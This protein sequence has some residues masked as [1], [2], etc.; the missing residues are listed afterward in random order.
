MTRRTGRRPGRSTTREDIL[1]AAAET[2]LEGSLAQATVRKIASRA[3]VD[4]ALIYRHFPSKDALFDEV[5]GREFSEVV[6][7][8]QPVS[9]GREL[10]LCAVEL[11]ED[12]RRRAMGMG[13]IR[14]A[15]SNEQAATLLRQL[16]GR[17]ILRWIGT[18]TRADHRE[19][20]V[21]LVAAHIVGLVIVRHQIGLAGA[22]D[23]SPDELVR[24]VSPVIEHYL[25]GDLGLPQRRT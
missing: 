15:M 8:D 2:F 9:D 23:A 16:V 13:A 20:R 24:V 22:K 11:W 19:L 7:L 14:A 5:I 4:P 6:G 1:D 17:T 21:S 25:H 12:R 3:G 18:S 10:V